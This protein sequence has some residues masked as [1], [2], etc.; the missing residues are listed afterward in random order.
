MDLNLDKLIGDLHDGIENVIRSHFSGVVTEVETDAKTVGSDVLT[1]AEAELEAVLTKLRSAI[2][3]TAP[4]AEPSPV[5]PGDAGGTH[6]EVT[7][8]PATS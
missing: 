5:Q 8:Q 7:G 4:G 2:A 1:E 3:P 6:A